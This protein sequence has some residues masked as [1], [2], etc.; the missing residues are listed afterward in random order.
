MK[1]HWRSQRLDYRQSVVNLPEHR[2][3]V[4]FFIFWKCADLNWC[5]WQT[6][7]ICHPCKHKANTKDPWSLDCTY[8][9][10]PFRYH[11]IVSMCF[12]IF[13]YIYAHFVRLCSPVNHLTLCPIQCVLCSFLYK[14][15]PSKSMNPNPCLCSQDIMIHIDMNMKGI[16]VN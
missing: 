12:S 4:I 16:E 3:N 13:T 15:L 9:H 10:F 7:H 5:D 8:I 2:Y 14:A 1:L 6:L 11:R